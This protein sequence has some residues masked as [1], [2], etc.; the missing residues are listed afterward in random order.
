MKQL[1][2]IDYPLLLQSSPTPSEGHSRCGLYQCTHV[3]VKRLA[4]S[5]ARDTL[6]GSGLLA[7]GDAVVLP[8]PVLAVGAQDVDV[9]ALGGDSAVDVADG[10]VGDGD[11]SSRRTGGLAVLVV[12]LDD[13]T[14]LG[15]VLEGDVL[16]DDI[17]DG[18]SSTGDSLD[19]DTVVRVRD[20]V[21]DDADLL[22]NVVGAST[23]RADGDT[24]TTAAV[25]AGEGDVGAGV[26]GKAVV[27]VLD[28]GAG[29]V[30]TSGRANIESISVVATLGVTEGVVKGDISQL[31]VVAGVDAEGLDG[32]VLDVE[33]LDLGVLHGVSVEELGLLLA[34]V[35]TLGIPPALTLAV[36]GVAGSTRDGE[37]VTAEGDERTLPL[38]VAKG[39]L[40]LEDDVGVIL[41]LGQVEDLASGDR[42]V[43]EDDGRAASLVLDG[44][45]G[46]G[47]SAASTVL[48]G[49]G[50]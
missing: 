42:D 26:D 4:R 45:L 33:A 2:S 9:G 18:T 23:D 5:T 15:D 41:E 25:T 43:L 38:L 8:R 34:A 20:D 13:N 10:E 27:L 14:V 6:A 7:T 29:D 21:V 44:S 50:H 16:V 46:V 37:T 24:V 1:V 17:G 40:A 30:D 36:D 47:E 35:G 49:S 22:D 11:T 28:V 12:L 39:G 32:G 31:D 3:G 19:A 48:N